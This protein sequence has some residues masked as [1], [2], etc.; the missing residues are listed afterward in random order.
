MRPDN[1]ERR[2]LAS[3]PAA[4][5]PP[6]STFKI[7][8]PAGALEDKVAKAAPTFPV[9]TAAMIEGVEPRTPTASPAAV[10][11]HSFATPATSALAPL[12]AQ[13]GAEKLVD[14]GRALRVQ[15]ATGARR[16]GA[17]DDPRRGRDRRRPRGRLLRDR[18]GQSAATPPDGAV[19]AAIGA[20]GCACCRRCWRRG[21]EADPRD[22]HLRRPHDQELHTHGRHRTGLAAGRGAVAQSSRARPAPRS[23]A[24]DRHEESPPEVTDLTAAARGGHHATLD[25]RFVAPAPYREPKIAVAVM[26]VGQGTAATP[27]RP[28]P[29]AVLKAALRLEVEV[30]LGFLALAGLDGAFSGGSAASPTSGAGTGS[31]NPGS[32]R[33]GRCC[34]RRRHHLARAAARS[35]CRTG[36]GR[37]ER[38]GRPRFPSVSLTVKDVV[39]VSV[40]SGSSSDAHPHAEPDLSLGQLLAGPRADSI[41]YCAVLDLTRGS[42]S[43][44]SEPGR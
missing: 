21:P 30:D 28:R 14:Y 37:T 3:A 31:A 10:A 39:G 24:D 20:D 13:L 15:R 7:I 23:C 19:G 4:P 44:T 32:G 25:A 18:P 11:A 12:G 26:L 40:S 1:G 6:G 36:C 35:A 43:A 41:R 29:G 2:W 27:P 17:L 42:G 5:Q 22:P 33:R 8:T 16:R 34:V 38:T 9:Q